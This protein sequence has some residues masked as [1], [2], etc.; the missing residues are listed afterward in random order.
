MRVLVCGGRNYGYTWIDGKKLV[1]YEQLRKMYDVLD[2]INITV[3]ITGRARGADRFS[4]LYARRAGIEIEAYPADWNQFG[5][6]AGPIRNAQMLREGRPGLVVAFPGGVGTAHMCSIA[7][8][9]GV[10]VK[11]VE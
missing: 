1:D 5:K 2:E 11:K 4:E 9:A 6:R 8:K 7:E 3:L 10:E